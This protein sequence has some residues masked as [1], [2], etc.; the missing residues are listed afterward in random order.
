MPFFLNIVTSG[1]ESWLAIMSVS[2]MFREAFP[3]PG[4][5]NNPRRFIQSTKFGAKQLVLSPSRLLPRC[6]FSKSVW[7]ICG[8]GSSS[9]LPFL[10]T[11]TVV[12]KFLVF[13]DQHLALHHPTTSW[14]VYGQ[15]WRSLL[16][17]KPLPCPS[18]QP[19]KR[20]FARLGN[21]ASPCPSLGTHPL[22]GPLKFSPPRD[23][24]K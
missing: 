9:S 2:V 3:S 12:P 11:E 6:S 10:D 21:L 19:P 5:G 18:L 1:S 7:S 16:P 23:F 24:G 22:W 17:M 14:V 20:G 13:Q 15:G 4:L 8:Q